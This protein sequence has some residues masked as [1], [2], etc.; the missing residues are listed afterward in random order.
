MNSQTK[1]SSYKKMFSEL[2]SSEDFFEVQILQRIKDDYDKFHNHDLIMFEN[3]IMRE[4]ISCPKCGSVSFISHGKD[5]NGSKRFKCKDCNKTFNL[6]S[7]TLFFASKVNLKAWFAFLESLLSGTSVRAACIV[8]KISLVT[9]KEWLKKIFITLKDYQNSIILGKNVWI[10]ETFVHE[11]KSKIIYLEEIGKIKKVKKQPRGISNNKICILVGTDE[12]VSFGE[13]V[14]HGRP[15]RIPNYK[16]CKRHIQEYSNVVG[17]EDTSLTYASNLMHWNRTQIKSYT[18]EAF[19]ELEPVDELCNRFK[20]FIGK[21]RGF[22]KDK[23]QDYINLFIF[24][25]NEMHKEN[26][27]YKVTM[28]L[29]K[30]MANIK[31]NH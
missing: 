22:E 3:M 1:N 26:D 6:I 9:G 15:Q 29:L 20:F 25:D 4:E 23:L 5:K 11:D 19:K 7:K 10:D 16:I 17:D 18:E 24:I 31:A 21:H 14:C 27:L 2:N 12:N 30:M 28:K 8:A 13:I